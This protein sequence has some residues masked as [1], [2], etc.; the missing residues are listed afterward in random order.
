MPFAG[1]RLGYHIEP[2]QNELNVRY[3]IDGVLY[4]VK[5][6][7]KED[8]AQLITSLK[9]LAKMDLNNS[10]IPQS[11]KMVLRLGEQNFQL[12]TLSFPNPH[13]KPQHQD[14]ESLHVSARPA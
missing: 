8:Q 10:R 14:R 13:E 11:S 3:R 6:P 9:K 2:D 12:N 5:S 1:T 7:P 4:K